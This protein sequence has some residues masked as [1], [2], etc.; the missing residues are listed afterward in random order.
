M[1]AKNFHRWVVEKN[2][3]RKSKP[4]FPTV[5]CIDD[6]LK[7]NRV[8]FGKNTKICTFVVVQNMKLKIA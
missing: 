3:P 1:N 6:F 5:I 8:F 2:T 4:Q 7:K